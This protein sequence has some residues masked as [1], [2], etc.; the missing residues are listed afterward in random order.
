MWY[1]L[2][3]WVVLCTIVLYPLLVLIAHY[4]FLA[5]SYIF[6]SILNCP[7]MSAL[8]DTCTMVLYLCCLLHWLLNS[9]MI[10]HWVFTC[11]SHLCCS[12]VTWDRD[13]WP[14]STSQ[15]SNCQRKRWCDADACTNS[16]GGTWC[17][18][19]E[20]SLPTPDFE[21]KD[22]STAVISVINELWKPDYSH[23][24]VWRSNRDLINNIRE[25]SKLKLLIKCWLSLH[26]CHSQSVC[27]CNIS[28]PYGYK[29]ND[30]HCYVS[31]IYT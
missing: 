20:V 11:S 3:L 27:N 14:L 18:Y 8:R 9:F 25:Q 15:A 23:D 17:Y 24:E 12:S 5:K 28:I 29:C 22:N 19:E 6:F 7:V 1:S 2:F 31:E 30:V 13:A 10:L 21:Q 26:K 16:T 4:V